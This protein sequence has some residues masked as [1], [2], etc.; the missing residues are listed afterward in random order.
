MWDVQD[1]AHGV[2]DSIVHCPCAQ[3][4][5][6]PLVKGGGCRWGHLCRSVLPWDAIW[7]E[8]QNSAGYGPAEFDLEFTWSCRN[9]HILH[10]YQNSYR[11]CHDCARFSYIS[12]RQVILLQNS[13]RS[14]RDNPEGL[15]KSCRTL[16][17][18]LHKRLN[19]CRKRLDS[20]R[21]FLLRALLE[22]GIISPKM[23]F[24]VT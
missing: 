15:T 22:G 2:S 20:C 12:A 13:Y 5:R 1:Y 3:Q 14:I 11:N 18:L 17:Q 23:F 7:Q 16:A 8:Y 6:H 4:N 21:T 10:V 19:S 9:C 24:F